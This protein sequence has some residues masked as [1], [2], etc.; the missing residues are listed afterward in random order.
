MSKKN[1][2]FKSFEELGKAYGISEK[3]ENSDKKWVRVRVIKYDSKKGFGFLKSSLYKDKIFF[4]KSIVNKS[5]I[6]DKLLNDQAILD[7]IIEKTVEGL[8]AKKLKYIEFRLPY[9]TNYLLNDEEPE[10][11]YLAYNKILKFN[12]KKFAFPNE[13]GLAFTHI[14]KKFSFNNFTNNY[15]NSLKKLP[16]NIKL[17][18]PLEIEWR[19]IIGLGTD[20]VHETGI[21]LH[22]IY[23]FPYIPG[24]AIKGAM[25]SYIISEFF[26]SYEGDKSNGALADPLFC[27]I[28]GCPKKSFYGKSKAGLIWFFDAYP[29]ASPKIEVDIMNPH[30]SEYYSGKKNVPPADYFN[31]VPIP[32]LTVGKETEFQF[33][34]GVKKDIK[35]RLQSYYKDNSIIAKTLQSKFPEIKLNK[36]SSLLEIAQTFIQLTLENFGLG[37]KTAVGYGYFQ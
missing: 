37:A 33:I 9:D 27:D 11:F 15:I 26:N 28:F 30:Y 8:Q 21:T 34:V 6:N 36:E 18:A 35:K 4:H 25:R 23:G 24:Q 17:L 32:F 13:I 12:E 10:N 5:K 20:T 16:L 22:H 31:P 3:S 1:K 29:T 7:A 2:S 14:F 19:L